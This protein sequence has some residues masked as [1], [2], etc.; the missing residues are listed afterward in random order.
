MQKGWNLMG[1]PL[2]DTGNLQALLPD[3]VSLIASK[4]EGEWSIYSSSNQPGST[5]MA[6]PAYKGFWVLADKRMEVILNG[7]Q[8][9]PDYSG[10][11]SGWSLISVEDGATIQAVCDIIFS[12]TNRECQHLFAFNPTSGWES[13]DFSTESGVLNNLSSSQG[14]WVNIQ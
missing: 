12:E 11:L 5:L 14:V 9:A 3:G 13:Y 1:T 8:N 4:G 2:S 6:L 7:N 10:L